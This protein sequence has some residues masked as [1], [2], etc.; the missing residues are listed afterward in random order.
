ML[1]RAAFQSLSNL[2]REHIDEKILDNI[3][4]QFCIGK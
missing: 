4:S 3:F 1:L 2:E